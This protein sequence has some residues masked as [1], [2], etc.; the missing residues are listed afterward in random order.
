MSIIVNGVELTEVIYAGVNLDTVKVKKG[1]A[2]AVT[3]FEKITQLATP[4]NVTADGTTVSWDAVENATSYEVIEGG[5]NVLGTVTASSKVTLKLTS[6]VY[7]SPTPCRGYVYYSLDNGNTWVDVLESNT[8]TSFVD[9]VLDNVTQIKFK[10]IA[11][12]S[13]YGSIESGTG[14]LAGINIYTSGHETKIS[15]NYAITQDSI[16]NVLYSD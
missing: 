16:A 8:G 14:S 10:C 11:D 6:Y 1:T 4:Q 7:S 12:G 2:E 3:V 9:I 13:T 5:N 15:D